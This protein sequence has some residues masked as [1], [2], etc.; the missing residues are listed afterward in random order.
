M[1]SVMSKKD[2]NMLFSASRSA[3]KNENKAI[4][5]WFCIAAFFWNERIDF[6]V[7][8][9]E[10]NSDSDGESEDGGGERIHVLS[11]DPLHGSHVESVSSVIARITKVR[12]SL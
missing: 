4:V 6:I 8:K 12:I 2:S 1:R 10:N 9:D 7:L 5:L 11:R 3:A